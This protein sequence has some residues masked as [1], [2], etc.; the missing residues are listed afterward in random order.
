MGSG[1]SCSRTLALQMQGL[2]LI[3]RNKLEIS[4]SV[5]LA[6]SIRGRQRLEGPF[7]VVYGVRPS[8]CGALSSLPNP[9]HSFYYEGAL[10]SVKDY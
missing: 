8:L 3:C 5:V 10:G 4:G 9:P 7:A 1:G 6:V 2:D